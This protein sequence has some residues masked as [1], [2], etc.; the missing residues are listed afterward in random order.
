M[1]HLFRHDVLCISNLVFWNLFIL[2][3]NPSC[4]ADNDNGILWWLVVDTTDNFSSTSFM[5]N[6]ESSMGTSSRI[7]SL[8]GEKCSKNSI[9]R[10]IT[11]IRN[12]FS[13]RD[14][15]IFLFRGQITTPNANNQIHFVLRDDD[16]TTYLHFDGDI[17][18]KLLAE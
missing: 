11:K 1:K 4:L 9:Q 16:L 17:D 15:L 3:Y 13:V 12:S 6:F 5:E 7:V 2:F 18:G 14:R 10:S 8:A